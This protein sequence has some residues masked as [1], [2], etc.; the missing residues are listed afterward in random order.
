M[1]SREGSKG[2]LFGGGEGISGP[3]CTQRARTGRGRGCVGVQCGEAGSG[4]CDR[5]LGTG[6]GGAQVGG[7]LSVFHE[8]AGKSPRRRD[9][10]RT[11]TSPLPPPVSPQPLSPWDHNPVPPALLSHSSQPA[12]RFPSSYVMSPP[13]RL[14]TA[15]RRPCFF[16]LLVSS[17]L[18]TYSNPTSIHP[19][20]RTPTGS[21]P[22]W[23]DHS[24]PSCPRSLVRMSYMQGVLPVTPMPR[25]PRGQPQRWLLWP[26]PSSLTEEV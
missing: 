17:L 19:L 12:A 15:L 8:E 13:P 16:V 2:K 4:R 18:S 14:L 25:V 3:Y 23:S 1:Q 10:W 5:A 21:F 24:G 11:N 9:N 26:P 20:A 7:C 22:S 6:E